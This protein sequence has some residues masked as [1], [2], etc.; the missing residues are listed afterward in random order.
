MDVIEGLR[1]VVQVAQDQMKWLIE[2]YMGHYNYARPH[3]TNGYITPARFEALWL[4]YLAEL[5]KNLGTKK[6]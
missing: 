6:C 3:S 5:E 2:E 1:S 4:K